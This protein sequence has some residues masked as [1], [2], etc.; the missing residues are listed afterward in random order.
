MSDPVDANQ[1]DGKPDG[2]M[3][4]NDLEAAAEAAVDEFER[5]AP[6]SPDHALRQQFLVS[7]HH[8]DVHKE[9]SLGDHWSVPWSDLMMVMF[10]LFAALVTAQALERKVPEYIDRDK[11]VPVEVPAPSFEALT[12]INVF[13]RSQQAVRETNIENVE[14]ALLDD[15][16][17]KVSVQGPML[18]DAGEDALRPDVREFLDV[19]AR[20]IRQVPYRV[21]VIGHT[22]DTPISNDRFASNWELSLMRATKVTRHLIAEGGIEPAR[23]TIMGRSQYDPVNSNDNEQFRSMNRRVEIII[24]REPTDAG[25]ETS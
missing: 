21:N 7:G 6:W 12:R 15:Q 16:S 10:V 23:F 8:E 17:V 2:A 19:L 20:V 5:P 22:D 13:E 9:D 18:F 11:P 4:Q 3:Q 24:T 25:E 14:I 1:P